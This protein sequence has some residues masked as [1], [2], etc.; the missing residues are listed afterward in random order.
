MTINKNLL[1]HKVSE[2]IT[3]LIEI[4]DVIILKDEFGE[5]F[6]YMYDES[7]IEAVKEDI[8]NKVK[9]KYILTKEK[10]KNNRFKV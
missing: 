2:N 9:L 1:L 6:C 4:G 5:Y 10:I 3:D 7:F 8:S